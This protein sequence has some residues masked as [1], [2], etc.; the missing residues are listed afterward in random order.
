M[1]IFVAGSSLSRN[2]IKQRISELQDK[3][4]VVTYNWA[5]YDTKEHY[6]RTHKD[7]KMYAK[8]SIQGIRSSNCLVVL[9]DN[10]NHSY[11]GVNCEIGF[12]IGIKIPIIVYDPSEIYKS[13]VFCYYPTV[14]HFQE[15]DGV[16]KRLNHIR[17]KL[18]R[19][20]AEEMKYLTSDSIQNDLSEREK[21]IFEEI[22]DASENK[23]FQL[24]TVLLD[25]KIANILLEYGYKIKN[26]GSTKII[27]WN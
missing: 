7:S 27:S 2:P 12:A 15:W 6:E 5:M 9:L 19:Y 3:G 11:R 22:K 4:F 25:D 13:N 20:T 17:N 18:G 10:S 8:N 23:E 26:M 1:N 21:E 14:K 24:E 16:V